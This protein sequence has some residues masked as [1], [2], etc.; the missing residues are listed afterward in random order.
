MTQVIK[1]PDLRPPPRGTPVRELPTPAQYRRNTPAIINPDPAAK[2]GPVNRKRL[3]ILFAVAVALH[4][5]V[6][7]AIWLSPPL[8]LKWEPSPDAWVQVVALPL[9][10]PA[11]PALP[12][13]GP[14]PAPAHVDHRGTAPVGQ[15]REYQS[16]RGKS[17]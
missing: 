3:L 4:V 6:L 2:I 13:P 15:S 9:K 12:A 1:F 8:R 14:K 17:R 10:P 16:N 11:A 7:F 5:L